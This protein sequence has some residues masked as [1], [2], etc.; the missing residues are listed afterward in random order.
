ML[1]GHNPHIPHA[2]L[3][4]D[5]NRHLVEITD[6]LLQLAAR[7]DCGWM[8]TEVHMPHLHSAHAIAQR[9]VNEDP[10]SNR[11]PIPDLPDH[12]KDSS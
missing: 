8:S 12:G 10:L 2:L 4:V 5:L 3:W 6:S 1:P 9:W 7:A 11:F